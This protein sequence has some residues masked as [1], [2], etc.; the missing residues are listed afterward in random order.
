MSDEAVK[1]GGEG[2]PSPAE[3]FPHDRGPLFPERNAQ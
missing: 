3:L 1:V 2:W